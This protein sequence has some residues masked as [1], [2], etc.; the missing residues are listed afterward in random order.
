MMFLIPFASLAILQGNAPLSLDD[1]VSIAVQN[2][3]SIRQQKAVIEKNRQKIHENEG[4]L[5]PRVAISG[6]YTRYDK[7]STANFGSATIVTQPIDPKNVAASLQ[8]PIDISGNVGRIVQAS[9][10]NLVASEETLNATRNDVKLNVRR[11]YLNILRAED[12]VGVAKLAVQE[13][14][15]RLKNVKVELEQGTKAKI[16]VIRIEAQVA[17]TQSDLLTAQNQVN[18]SKQVLNNALGRPIETDFQTVHVDNL[19]AMPSVDPSTIDGAAQKVRPEAKALEKT[20]LALAYIR[21]ATERG[22]NPSLNLAI[23]YLRNI[24]AKGFSSRDESTTGTLTLNFP[25]FDSGVTRAQVKQARQDEESAKTQLEQ[26]RL[27]I[28]LEVRQAMTN[29]SNSKARLDVAKR[30]TASAEENYRI[31]KVRLA[32]GAGITI[33][34]TDALTQLTQARNSLVLARYDYWTAYSELQRAVGSDELQQA[35]GGRN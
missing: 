13:A 23:N 2:A 32:E 31:A 6:T 35:I 3:F 1:A 20:Q 30:Q 5:G 10:A 15:E 9:K 22:Q 11:S 24:D 27:G 12:Q 25:I 17:Q 7:E 18:L 29:M 8:L 16:D 28:S 34:I 4:Q 14:E 33:E 19:P 26:V 21:Q